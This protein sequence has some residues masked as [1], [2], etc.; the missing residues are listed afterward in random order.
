[1]RLTGREW[2]KL[3]DL[4]LIGA[5]GPILKEK[6]KISMVTVNKALKILRTCM[7]M[8]V[9]EIFSGTVEVDE[10]YLGG[11]WKNKRKSV[12]AKEPKS[13]RDLG[14]TKQP[15]FG[16]LTRNGQVWAELVSD[17]EAKDL[18]PLITRQVKSGTRVC[19]DT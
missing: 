8:D 13:K 11:Q 4:Y 10:K 16:I 2:I 17:T 3:V 14:T 6:L 15:V 1:M 9:P 7:S 12:K 5:N 19:S 18:I